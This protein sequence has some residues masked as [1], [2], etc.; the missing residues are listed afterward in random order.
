MHTPGLKQAAE[1]AVITGERL[2]EE[3]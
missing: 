1:K 3:K 2:E